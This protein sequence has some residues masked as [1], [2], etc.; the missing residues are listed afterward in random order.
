ML[1]AY[2]AAFCRAVIGLTFAFSFAGKVRDVPSFVQTIRRFKLLP[3]WLSRTAAMAFLCGEAVVVFAMIPHPRIERSSIPLFRWE[4]GIVTGGFLLA[5]LMLLV[6]CAALASVL[7]R[8]IQT[9]CNCFGASEK[10]VSSYDIVRNIGFI[11]CALNGCGAQ[12]G[13]QSSLV[14]LGVMECGLA[15]MVAAVFIAVWIQLG[16]ILAF[17]K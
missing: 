6:F 7:V 13:G 1:I 11:V 17:F 10:Q 14:D 2:G 15:G 8:K 5:A 9:S 12:I 4:K 16:E 3:D